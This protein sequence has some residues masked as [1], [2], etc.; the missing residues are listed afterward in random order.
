MR[1]F[2]VELF[3]HIKEEHMKNTDGTWIQATYDET[4]IMPMLE[5]AC[6]SIEYIDEYVYIYNYGTGENDGEIHHKV[7]SDA[8]LYVRSLPRYECL[9]KYQKYVI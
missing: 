4:F 7:Q 8:A 9:E 5:M 1:T 6:D 2:R 3:H